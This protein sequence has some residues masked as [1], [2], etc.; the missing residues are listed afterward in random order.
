MLKNKFILSVLAVT[1]SVQAIATESVTF[2]NSVAGVAN[3]TIN[4]GELSSYYMYGTL[5]NNPCAEGVIGAASC[6]V[7]SGNA[8]YEKFTSATV[9]MN[10]GTGLEYLGGYGVPGNAFDGDVT[11]NMNGGQTNYIVGGTYFASRINRVRKTLG[12]DPG[13]GHDPFGYKS[14]YGQE[15]NPEATKQNININVA[16]GEVGQIRG[17][18]NG[19]SNSGI[20]STYLKKVTAAG[21]EAVAAFMKSNPAAVSGDVNINVTGGTVGGLKGKTAAIQGAGGTGY[22]V[23]GTV[24]I[25]IDKDATIIGDILTGSSNVYTFTGATDVTINGGTISGNVYAGGDGSD[26]P[27]IAGGPAPTV[28]GST[29]VTL[30]GGSIAKNVYGA[31]L[32]DIVKGGTSIIISNAGTTVG[33]TIYGGGVDATVE[34]DRIL[35]VDSSY[36]GTQSYKVADFTSIAINADVNLSGLTAAAEGT[37][38]AIA[39][40]AML[41]LTGE[42]VKHTITKAVGGTISIDEATLELAEGGTLESDIVLNNHATLDL[43]GI[44]TACDIVVYGC[45]LAGANHYT[46]NLTVDNGDLILTEDT[47]AGSVTVTNNGSI[48]G[49]SVTT[50]NLT[51]NNSQKPLETNI[52]IPD[53]GTITLSNGGKLIVEGDVNLGSDT[54]IVLDGDYKPGDE[55]MRVGGE[56]NQKENITLTFGDVKLVISGGVATLVSFFD[57]NLADTY[58]IS[59]WGIATASRSFVNTIRGQRNNTACIAN[60]RGTVW[61]AEMGG[62]HDIEGADVTL[63]GAAV[64]ADM[65]VGENSTI[66]IAVGYTEGDVRPSGLRSV[67]QEGGYIAMYGEHGLKKLSST[68]CLSMD[69]VAAYGM[70]DSDVQGREWEQDSVQLNTRMKWNKKMSDRLCVSV[71]GGLEY[72]ST[73]SDVVEGVKTGSIQN[74]RGELGVNARYVAIGSAPVTDGKSGLVLARG[75]EKLI[76]NGEVR[77]VNDIV[78]SNP[79][80]EMYDVRGKGEYNPGRHGVGIEAGATYR[81]GERW[82]ASVNYGFNALQDSKEHRVNAGASYT[83]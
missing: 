46:G 72:F 19:H 16:G 27:E 81:F 69:W 59:N 61:V 49:Y 6:G 9:T 68:S 40:G 56:I 70:T 53:N 71:F 22:S 54:A 17:G 25:S 35:T 31:G 36:T 32:N 20:Y 43:K 63:T 15:D 5:N 45:T 52:N 34:G 60:G 4:G 14:N 8:P 37:S 1:A 58:T 42:G 39:D 7:T 79:T 2:D 64:G 65:K 28:K 74:L 30:S 41:K 57:Y 48:S 55:I 47:C 66:G 18:H 38:V 11:V 80:V 26:D 51:V 3:V 75:C 83:F 21:E 12:T 62:N 82:S 33:G 73:E 23:D 77:Y 44:E 13:Y 24:R 78:R 29:K 76:L 67:D 50:N 10:G